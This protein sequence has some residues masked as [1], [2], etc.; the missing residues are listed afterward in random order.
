MRRKNCASPLQLLCP[1]S[2]SASSA[3]FCQQLIPYMLRIVLTAKTMPVL[4][5][6]SPGL[7]RAQ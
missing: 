6:R 1:L 2:T 5:C 7:A 4:R 3:G